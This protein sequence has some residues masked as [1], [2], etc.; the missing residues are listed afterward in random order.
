[1]KENDETVLAGEEDV[2]V[3]DNS[4][5]QY[6]CQTE[7]YEGNVLEHYG[8]YDGNNISIYG[9]LQVNICRAVKAF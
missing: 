9:L 1:M 5:P 7:A 3:T 8:E 2:H 4:V 6:Q